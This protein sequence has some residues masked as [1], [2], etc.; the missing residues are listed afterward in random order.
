M[1][2]PACYSG[3]GRARRENGDQEFEGRA[4]RQ[5]RGILYR[6]KTDITRLTSIKPEEI[7]TGVRIP[8]N[9]AGARFYFEKVADRD[10]WD[11]ALQGLGCRGRPADG[12]WPV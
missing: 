9:W 10:T 5:R 12:L 1:P 2:A 6:P 4:G 7:L 8:N 3:A 11:F